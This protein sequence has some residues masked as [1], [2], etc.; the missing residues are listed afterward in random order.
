MNTLDSLTLEIGADMMLEEWT[1]CPKTS[2]TSY[3]TKQRKKSEQ[4]EI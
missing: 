3:K 2:V 4:L 1:D